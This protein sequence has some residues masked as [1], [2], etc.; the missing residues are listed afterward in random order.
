MNWGKKDCKVKEINEKQNNIKNNTLDT[1]IN[2][3]PG[4][5]FN[6]WNKVLKYKV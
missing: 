4:L 5:K 3:T 2:S 1:I 6:Y